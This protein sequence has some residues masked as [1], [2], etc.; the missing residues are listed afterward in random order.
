M[1]VYMSLKGSETVLLSYIILNAI[2]LL[3]EH[4][5]NPVLSRSTIESIIDDFFAFYSLSDEVTLNYD[6]DD[7]IDAFLDKYS[8]FF[9]VNENNIILKRSVSTDALDELIDIN[10][11]DI[12]REVGMLLSMY[13]HSNMDLYSLLGIKIEKEVYTTLINLE[14]NIEFAYEKYYKYKDEKLLKK[15]KMDLLRRNILLEQIRHSFSIEEAEDLYKYGAY[16]GVGNVYDESVLPIKKANYDFEDRVN[17]SPF[18]EALF[19]VDSPSDLAVQRK[20][21]DLTHP[22]FYE[23]TSEENFYRKV[24][25]IIDIKSQTDKDLINAKARLMYVLDYL[26]VKGN[27]YDYLILGKKKEQAG[28]NNYVFME[29]EI[30]F[31]IDELFT[32]A[33]EEMLFEED[34]NYFNKIKASLIEAYYDLTKDERII[35]YIENNPNYSHNKIICSLFDNVVKKKKK[36]IKKLEEDK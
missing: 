24:Y 36:K 23:Q 14:Y 19:T 5:K 15:I 31:L 26:C 22:Y 28:N 34:T 13:F 3:K 12:D 16:L 29:K 10:F 9:Y 35:P 2:K 33:D 21:F 30:F 11:S 25:E 6:L 7:K 27:T 1:V 4:K 20:L 32:Y 8:R 18:H 17:E